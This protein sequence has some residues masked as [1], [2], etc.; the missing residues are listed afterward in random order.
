MRCIRKAQLL[1]FYFKLFKFFFKFQNVVQSRPA[2]AKL[3]H[4]KKNFG[5]FLYHFTNF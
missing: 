1:F 2:Y 5:T 4:Y 3:L